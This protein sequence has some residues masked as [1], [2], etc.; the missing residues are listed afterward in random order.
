MPDSLDFSTTLDRSLEKVSRATEKF[1]SAPSTAY[2]ETVVIETEVIW[3]GLIVSETLYPDR[4]MNA[5]FQLKEI[6]NKILVDTRPC[7]Q[8]VL[9]P[10]FE[11]YHN[12]LRLY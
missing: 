3:G 12:T 5:V 10:S 7:I 1:S 2:L 6:L 4:T 9:G 11:G 8:S